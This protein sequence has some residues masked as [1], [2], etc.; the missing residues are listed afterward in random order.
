MY[1]PIKRPT[2]HS[3]LHVPYKL[4]KVLITGKLLS[5]SKDVE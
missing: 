2:T 5:L 3:P 4:P 1:I